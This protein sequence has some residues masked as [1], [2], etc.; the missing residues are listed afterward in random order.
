MYENQSNKPCISKPCTWN[1]PSKRTKEGK[2]ID[3]LNF[4][5]YKQ[6]V[7]RNSNIIEIKKKYC[8]S[9]CDSLCSRLQNKNFV[10]HHL[11]YTP[12]NEIEVS[13]DLNVGHQEVVT[14]DTITYAS[15]E[16]ID[17]QN[18]LQFI[19]SCT[20][21]DNQMPLSTD[22]CNEVELRTRGQSENKLWFVARKGRITAS[23]FHDVLKQKESTNPM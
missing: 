17:I 13:D 16:F 5:K 3:Q 23:L 11:L 4:K 20:T 12:D 19:R 1:K 14:S 21:F 6:D 2:T 7:D 8:K 18:C 10:I 15:D 22:V 9:F